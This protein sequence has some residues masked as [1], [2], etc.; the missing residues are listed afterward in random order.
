MC[1]WLIWS[2]I[3]VL[4]AAGVTQLTAIFLSANSFPKDL[5]RA[6]TAALAAL[7][8]HQQKKYMEF[9][10][11]LMKHNGRIDEKVLFEIAR[12]IDLNI[13][14]FKKDF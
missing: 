8:A 1:S 3:L 6:I 14:Q 9:H 7:A 12:K 4:A 5:V 2:K 11:N 13:S 10:I